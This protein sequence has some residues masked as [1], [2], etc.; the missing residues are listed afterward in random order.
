VVGP[1]SPEQYR[2]IVAG[3]AKVA[4]VSIEEPLVDTILHEVLSSGTNL[5]TQ[6]SDHQYLSADVLPML[7]YALRKLWTA[8][9]STIGITKGAYRAMGGICGAIAKHADDILASSSMTPGELE[10]LGKAMV[11]LVRLEHG[12]RHGRQRLRLA[13]VPEEARRLIDR[14]VYE[15][16]LVSGVAQDGNTS[17]ATDAGE[18]VTLAHESL[19]RIWPW[20]KQRVEA[21]TADL[22]RL[23][24]FRGLLERYEENKDALLDTLSLEEALDL[25][26]GG[27]AEVQRDSARQLIEASRQREEERIFQAARREIEANFAESLRLA[28]EARAIAA[29]EPDLALLVAWQAVMQLENEVTETTF[30]ELL[31]KLPAEMTIVQEGSGIGARAQ[32]TA[33]LAPNEL[34]LVTIGPESSRICLLGESG[35]IIRERVVPG[36]GGL[37]VAVMPR[38]RLCVTRYGD[39][40]RLW[41][42]N[43]FEQLDQQY[44]DFGLGYSGAGTSCLAEGSVFLLVS[45]HR[46]CRVGIDEA[47]RRFEPSEPW[48]LA[49]DDEELSDFERLG[50]IVEREVILDRAGKR[51]LARGR[52]LVSVTDTR[53]RHLTTIRREGSERY[54]SA[55]LLS[56]DRV[57]TGTRGGNGKGE[58]WDSKGSRICCFAEAE[59]DFLILAV[60]SEG[61]RFVTTHFGSGVVEVWDRDGKR[62]G[63]TRKADEVRCA[64]F[65]SDGLRVAH[66]GSNGWIRLWDYTIDFEVGV[67]VGHR[68]SIRKVEFCPQDR[69]LLCST[70]EGGQVRQWRLRR[71]LLPELPAADYPV[72]RLISAYGGLLAV[73]EAVKGNG[74]VQ[75]TSLWK[76]GRCVGTMFGEVVSDPVGGREDEYREIIAVDEQGAVHVS[77]IDSRANSAS[78]IS[79]ILLRRERCRGEIERGIVSGDRTRFILILYDGTVEVWN[80]RG[81]LQFT[82]VGEN[83]DGVR[84]HRTGVLNSGVSPN[85]NAIVVGAWNGMVWVWNAD[86]SLRCRFIAEHGHSDPVFDFAVD[87]LGEMLMVG[88]RQKAALWNWS[89]KRLGDLAVGG[90][91]VHCV[92]FSPKG[93]F[94]VTVCTEDNKGGVGL[95]F[96]GRDGRLHA[97]ITEPWLY[98]IP[99][100]LFDLDDKFVVLQLMDRLV[101]INGLGDVMDEIR[102]PRGVEVRDASVSSDGEWVMGLFSD[103]IIRIWSYKERRRIKTLPVSSR[104]PIACS[105]DR[106]VLWTASAGGAV[107]VHP[108]RIRDLLDLAVRRVGPL[109]G[110]EER[111][112]FGITRVLLPESVQRLGL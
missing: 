33:Y 35:A 78:K 36:Q 12:G 105:A 99:E 20:L 42:L 6:G 19:I 55:A 100:L 73:G 62:L 93:S 90:Y 30:R 102:G 63:E 81:K 40:L 27:Y 21:A 7:A 60:D 39:V 94:L 53:G 8:R 28:Q 54:A 44:S 24:R 34:F 95:K 48:D 89:G 69:S 17:K 37:I 41:D 80:R 91:K 15:R 13:M 9:D 46:V 29:H 110:S 64:A 16:L 77:V 45:A 23:E 97:T 92:R 1:L 22:R 2:D 3:P 98:R 58:L 112:R 59:G 86:G 71:T 31:G 83:C 85:D 47:M 68:R 18:Y 65:S 76:E 14:L 88:L 25:R 108:L 26:K 4:G 103:R 5:N 104:G 75:K 57:V 11:Q 101:V 52:T 96:W 87:P 32:S 50:R 56:N 82:A 109:F 106:A 10:S 74:R 111:R 49:L 66:G 51:V 67:L 79:L 38:S 43:T 107:E 84:C 61:N 72:T 70:D